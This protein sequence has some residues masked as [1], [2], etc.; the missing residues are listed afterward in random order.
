L[1]DATRRDLSLVDV[2][3]QA[4]L[5]FTIHISY[6]IRYM[7]EKQNEHDSQSLQGNGYG[8]QHRALV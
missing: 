8:R 4:L 3:M 6:L 7:E 1:A 2:D 5:C